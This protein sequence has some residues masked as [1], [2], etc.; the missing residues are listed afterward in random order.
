MENFEVS[1]TVREWTDNEGKRHRI[2]E[3]VVQAG[4]QVPIENTIFMNPRDLTARMQGDDDGDIVGVTSD[5]RVRDLFRARASESVYEIEPIGGKFTHGSDSP[6]GHKYLET[7]PRGPVGMTTIWQAQLLAVGDMWGALAMGVLNQEAI[8]SA[9]RKVAW[10]DVRKA[11]HS[12]AWY[13]KANGNKALKAEAKLDE[14]EYENDPNQPIGWPGEMTKAWVIERLN[15]FGCVQNEKVWMNPLAWRLQHTIKDGKMVKLSKRVHGEHWVSTKAKDKGWGGGNTVHQCADLAMGIW[16]SK[17]NEWK[18]LGLEGETPK[19]RTDVRDLLGVLMRQENAGTTLQANTWEEYLELRS[20]TIYQVDENGKV[21]KD[22]D[23]KDIEIGYSIE[24][25]GAEFKKLLSTSAGKEDDDHKFV[26]IENLTQQLN[27]WFAHLS[28][29]ELATIYYWE[30]TST[31]KIVNGPRVTY[32]H[33]H[34]KD[35]PPYMVNKPNYGFKAICWPGSPLLPLLG[36]TDAQ[37]CDFLSKEKRLGK[38]TKWGMAQADPFLALNA[39]QFKDQKHGG[40]KVGEDGARVEMHQCKT[41]MEAAHTSLVRTWR[42]TRT[43]GEIKY[44]IGLISVLKKPAPRKWAHYEGPTSGADEFG[45]VSED[46][47]ECMDQ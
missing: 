5:I 39:W 19:A 15:K 34:T 40:E 4:R 47:Y 42:N 14:A 38:I 8:D 10:T 32:T 16:K 18:L 26:G 36:I 24:K 45:N 25:Y 33:V 23:G 22:Q 27:Q 46:Y 37:G 11:S 29:A 30:N 43:K 31:W 9:K 17:A 7:D 3:I 2:R 13:E 6:E 28:P 1:T 44:M 35:C 41:C 21:L 20:R 12:G